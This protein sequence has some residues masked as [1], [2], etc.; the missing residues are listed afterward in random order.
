MLKN[1]RCSDFKLN[2]TWDIWSSN[3]SIFPLS[4]YDETPDRTSLPQPVNLSCL[5]CKL[6]RVGLYVLLK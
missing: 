1:K 6:Y 5:E 3:H 2:E 4:V